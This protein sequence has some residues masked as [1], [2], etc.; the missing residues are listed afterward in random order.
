MRLAGYIKGVSLVVRPLRG[1]GVE[2]TNHYPELSLRNKSLVYMS[3]STEVLV[4]KF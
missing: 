2:T 1:G 4:S 3:M